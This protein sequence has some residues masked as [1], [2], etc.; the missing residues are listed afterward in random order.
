MGLSPE[1]LYLQLRQLVEE[2]PDL[3]GPI[4]SDTNRW[5]GRAISR[6][7]SVGDTA[8]V[9]SLKNA[10]QYLSSNANLSHQRP[11]YLVHCLCDAWRRPS[12]TPQPR[13]R[14]AFYPPGKPF[15]TMMAVGKVLKQAKADILFIDPY[16]GAK[17]LEENG[18]TGPRSD[19]HSPV[20][21]GGQVQGGIEASD[22]KV[23]KAV[24]R[25][26]PAGGSCCVTAE[27]P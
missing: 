20:M 11:D 16:A 14:I 1:A 25:E 15:D 26:P 18:A 2:M 13:C 23:A 5:L 22:R 10:A 7:E 27:A 24:W 6:V 3:T 19:P 8:D 17:V 12:R 21:R 9:I 4:T